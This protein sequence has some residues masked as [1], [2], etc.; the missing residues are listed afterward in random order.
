MKLGFLLISL[1]MSYVKNR[2]S[3]LKQ[4]YESVSYQKYSAET[5]LEKR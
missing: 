1:W 3:L 5:L 4:E 2:C